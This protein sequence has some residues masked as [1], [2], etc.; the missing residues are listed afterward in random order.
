MAEDA[1]NTGSTGG[2]PEEPPTSFGVFYPEN[3][4][5]AA[6]AAKTDADAAQQ[7][8]IASGIAAER[9]HEI[10]PDWV[11]ERAKQAQKEESFG[12]K[13]G[14]ALSFI[15]SDTGRYESEYIEEAHKGSYF[16]L[17]RELTE[18]EAG[19][20]GTILAAN[21]CYLARYYGGSSVRDLIIGRSG[22]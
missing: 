7:A 4:I 22:I 15:F 2:L 10:G 9:T 21:G 17:I 14:R 12:D 18:E 20:I 6:F 13:V 8:I 3:D 19:G 16:L 11:L 5:V 1:T